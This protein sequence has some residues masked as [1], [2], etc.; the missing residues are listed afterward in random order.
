M[1]CSFLWRSRRFRRLASTV[2]IE[3]IHLEVEGSPGFYKPRVYPQREIR[4][5][6][7]PGGCLYEKAE[8]I[9]L[10]PLIYV[11]QIS[12]YSALF[13]PACGWRSILRTRSDKGLSHRLCSIWNPGLINKIQS[14]VYLRI[15]LCHFAGLLK[16]VRTG[17]HKP[18]YEHPSMNINNTNTPT[19]IGTGSRITSGLP[20]ITE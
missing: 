4:G 18:V 1:I 6:A 12:M 9:P 17:R 15:R 2:A 11:Q 5:E 19:I 14:R 8:R 7:N 13:G 10:K 3:R 16:F 20:F